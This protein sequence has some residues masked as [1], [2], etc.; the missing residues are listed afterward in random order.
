MRRSVDVHQR[1]ALNWHTLREEYRDAVDDVTDPSAWT[2]TWSDG[3][4]S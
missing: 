3:E 2:Q 4:R 1:L